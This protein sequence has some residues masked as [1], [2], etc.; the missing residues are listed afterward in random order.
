MTVSLI[1]TKELV[2][3]QRDIGEP[4]K[5][6]GVEFGFGDTAISLQPK[7][8]VGAVPTEMLLEIDTAWDSATSAAVDIG[9]AGDADRYMPAVD[10]KSTAGTWFRQSTLTGASKDGYRYAAVLPVLIAITNVGAPT[11]GKARLYVGYIVPK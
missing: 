6:I 5:W 9:D 11:V 2:R 8:P 7:M 1:N 4:E 3:H 10:L